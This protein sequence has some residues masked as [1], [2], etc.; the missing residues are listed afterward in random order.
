VSEFADFNQQ[1]IEQFRQNGGRLDFGPAALLLLTHTGAK[2]GR[3]YTSPLAAYA[4]DGHVYVVASK[5]GAPA[6]PAWF[7]NLTAN[8]KV[9]VEFDGDRY[10]A[11]AR[12]LPGDERDALFPRIVER[13]PQFGEYQKNTSRTIPLIELE[14]LD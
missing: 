10:E 2:S 1:M 5:G 8:P 11:R 12:V 9:T 13:M 14:R 4:E 3:Q 7:H 6:N